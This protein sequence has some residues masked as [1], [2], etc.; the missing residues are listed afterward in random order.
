[1]PLDSAEA[2]SK[3]LSVAVLTAWANFRAAPERVPSRIRPFDLGILAHDESPPCETRESIL[4]TGDGLGTARSKYDIEKHYSV[5]G[6]ANTRRISHCMSG[7]AFRAHEEIGD[8]DCSEPMEKL[9]LSWDDQ[10]G[11]LKAE[12]SG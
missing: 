5:D 8:I 10:N 4:P 2:L 9:S 12:V 7:V 11:R 1:M 6:W 3:S